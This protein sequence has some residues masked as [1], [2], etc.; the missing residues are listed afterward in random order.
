MET[1]QYPADFWRGIP[2]KDF[3]SNSLVLANAFQF[4]DVSRPDGKKELSINWNDCEEALTTALNQRKP[5]GKLQFPAGVANLELAKVE[6][7]LSA[8]INQGLFSYER[9]EIDGN[10]YHGNLLITGT[11]DKQSRSLVSS[12]LALVAGT[13]I[14]YQPPENE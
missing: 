10:P 11:L 9:N 14:T 12:G 6:L 2:N 3:I 1:T 7:F 5:N 4:D 13:N 8:F